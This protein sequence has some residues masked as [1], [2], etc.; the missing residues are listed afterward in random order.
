MPDHSVSGFDSVNVGRTVYARNATG[1]LTP[2]IDRNRAHLEETRKTPSES[3]LAPVTLALLTAIALLSAC[4]A[5][6]FSGDD[7]TPRAI[8]SALIPHAPIAIDGDLDFQSQAVSEGWQ[9]DGT[10]G[11]P[12]VISNYEI[13]NLGGSAILIQNTRVHFLVNDS[14]IHDADWGINLVNVMNGTVDNNT[15]LACAIDIWVSSS[16]DLT[17]SNNDVSD[18]FRIQDSD[19]VEVVSNDLSGGGGMFL[20]SISNCTVTHNEI[21]AT[22]D[23]GIWLHLLSDHNRIADNNCTGISGTGIS[24]TESSFENVIEHNN[25]SGSVTGIKLTDSSHNNTV[26]NNI[27][28]DDVGKGIHLSNVYNTTLTGNVLREG[29]IWIDGAEVEMWDSHSISADNSINGKVVRYYARQ[30]SGTVPV[31]AGQVILASC[32]NMVVN[33]TN[34]SEVN[35]AGIL[36]GYSSSCTVSNNRCSHGNGGGI[37]LY[38]SPSNSLI[39]NNCSYNAANGIEVRGQ[40][41]RTNIADNTFLAELYSGMN[42]IVVA[43]SGSCNVAGNNCSSNYDAVTV[44]NSPGC[45]V[46]FNNLSFSFCEGLTLDSDSGGCVV[47][48]NTFYMNGGFGVYV[49]SSDNMIWHNIF[50]GNSGTTDV[51]DPSKSQARDDGSNNEW[52]NNTGGNWWSD[53]QSPDAD[54]DGIVDSPYLLYGTAGSQDELPLTSK[55]SMVPI[56]E[57]GSM[58]LVLVILVV[59]VLLMKEAGRKKT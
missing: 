46:R 8:E 43:D 27:C 36:L 30:T 2:R 50:M 37:Y 35:P 58:P 13:D 9:G 19:R 14:R 38:A 47:T 20:P 23:W 57:F 59:A 3:R 42:G 6:L 10:E 45:T 12:F 18:G 7:F 54:S 28:L 41:N 21:N 1:G 48:N 40:S 55:P 29:G 31:D 26:A 24:V 15:C 16:A 53:W 51:Y 4:A 22:A 11:D 44:V 39:E 32:S 34:C 25:C 56:P 17:I 33:D 5:I 52:N 49:M